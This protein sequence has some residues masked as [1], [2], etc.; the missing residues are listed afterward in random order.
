MEMIMKLYYSPAAC[1][2]ASHIL[3]NEWNIPHTTQSVDLRTHKTSK[4]EDFYTINPK[5]Y[6]PALTLDNGYTL[7]ENIAIL[8]YLSDSKGAV[9]GDKYQFLEWLAFIS[10]ELHKGIGALFGLKDGPAEVVKIIKEKAAKRL[11]LIHE[12]LA[13]KEFIFGNMFTA[14]DA[15]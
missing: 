11:K 5:G 10:T 2:M 6:V 7:T 3:L 9:K 8:S 1:S 13:C 12:H 14:A 4:G 15:Y